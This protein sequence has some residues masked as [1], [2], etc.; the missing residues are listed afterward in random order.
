MPLEHFSTLGAKL[1]HDSGS[2]SLITTASAEWVPLSTIYHYVLA[3]SPSP[4]AAKIAISRARKNGELRLHAEVREHEAEPGLQL[5]PG[6]QPL[7]QRS[8]RDLSLQ[9]FV[10]LLR[11]HFLCEAGQAR[12]EFFFNPLER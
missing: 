10:D 12:W 2:A 8:Q 11:Q 5:R 4:E 7:L 9:L 6:E 1:T 3:K